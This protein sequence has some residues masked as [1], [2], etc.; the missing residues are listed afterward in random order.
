ME[1]TLLKYPRSLGLAPLLACLSWGCGAE[2]PVSFK[3]NVALSKPRPGMEATKQQM[4]DAFAK[5]KRDPGKKAA[6]LVK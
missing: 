4:L 3:D 1:S 5:A 6:N 2:E